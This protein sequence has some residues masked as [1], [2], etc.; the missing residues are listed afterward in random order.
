MSQERQ[1]RG[2]TLSTILQSIDQKPIY[3]PQGSLSRLLKMNPQIQDPNFIYPGQNIN[4]G[5]DVRAAAKG[6]DLIIADQQGRGR[7]GE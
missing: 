7:T 5:G 3:G 6:G 4:L 1:Q 2:D